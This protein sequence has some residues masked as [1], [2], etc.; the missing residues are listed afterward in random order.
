MGISVDCSDEYD[1]SLPCQWVDVTN[2]P[3]GQY[4]LV[5]KVNSYEE[6]DRAGRPEMTYANNYGTAC[7]QISYSAN[8]IMNMTAIPNCNQVVLDCNGIAFGPGVPD[9]EGQCNTGLLTGD[10]NRD[11]ARNATD[12]DLYL[13]QAIA[14][15]ANATACT[16][17]NA[18]GKFSLHDAA[19]LQQCSIHATDSIYWGSR[20]SCAFPINIYN[21]FDRPNFR[22]QTLNTL[23][24]YIDIQV[25]NPNRK[26]VGFDIELE[27]VSI[28]SVKNLLTQFV[29]MYKI[30]AINGRIIALAT[31]EAWL[32]KSTS[33]NNLLRVYYSALTQDTICLKVNETVNEFYERSNSF[34]ATPS[35][36]V[37]TTSSIQELSAIAD[38]IIAYP[39]P[40]TDAITVL[41]P[42]SMS[43]NAVLSLVN[44]TGQVVRSFP[45]VGQ[46]MF[47]IERND[48][49]NGI[50]LLRVAD[51][52]KQAFTKV[53]FF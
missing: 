24:K 13:N 6:P 15:T 35:C 50:Y 42:P 36:K 33:Y 12:I 44:T 22:F 25:T 46:E 7:F 51:E 10:I 8:G 32:P 14:P 9:C 17:L 39:N 40:A 30:D 16:D 19:L 18:D 1:Y 21:Q 48:L 41:I 37:N 5:I 45:S 3:A 38:E 47:E 34:V 27:G 29:P 11:A 49:S 20:P 52:E 53:V 23:E 26:Q 2:I 4:Q 28:D 31:T 43:K